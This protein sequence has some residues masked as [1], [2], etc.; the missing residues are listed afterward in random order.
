MRLGA[1]PETFLQNKDGK[2][3]S[4]IGLVHGNKW[5]PMQID[6]LPKG[7]TLQQDNVALEF[8]IPP[9]SN[10]QAFI[11]YIQEVKRAGLKIVKNSLRYSNE[12]CVIFDE[13]QMQ[14]AEA[15]IF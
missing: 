4:V 11:E 9:A 14:T 15:H 10:K 1:D 8:G 13:D 5:K 2:F 3:I 7:F 12:S 6:Y